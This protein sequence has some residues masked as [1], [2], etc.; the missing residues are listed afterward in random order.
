MILYLLE[1]IFFSLIY[2]LFQQFLQS[3]FDNDE[4]ELYK[5]NGT[6]GYLG[7][8]PTAYYKHYEPETDAASN[9]T[10]LMNFLYVLNYATPE[11]FPAQIE[12]IFDVDTFVRNLAAEVSTG[13][14][15]GVW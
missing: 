13:Q 6:F 3:R 1:L 9:T 8:D 5:C 10:N 2:F 7:T 15:D 4:G 14:F 12:S 11:E